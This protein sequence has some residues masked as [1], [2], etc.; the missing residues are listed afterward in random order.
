MNQYR[1]GRAREYASMR[2]LEAAGYWCVRAAGSHGPVDIV[3]VSSLGARFIQTKL[4][5]ARVT[6]AEREILKNL[7]RPKNS[8]VEIWTWRDRVREP[9]IEVVG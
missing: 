6:P 9:S 5:T 3:A 4:N 2:L 1:R 8:T 7:P